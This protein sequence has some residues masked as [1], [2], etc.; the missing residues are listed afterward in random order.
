MSEAK[1]KTAPKQKRTRDVRGDE[2]TDPCAIAFAAYFEKLQ[3]GGATPDQ[4]REVCKL[5]DGHHLLDKRDDDHSCDPESSTFPAN[6]RGLIEETLSAPAEATPAVRDIT[7][8][9]VIVVTIEDGG[10]HYY[11][12]TES[13]FDAEIKLTEEELQDQRDRVES[14]FKSNWHYSA[15]TKKARRTLPSLPVPKTRRELWMACGHTDRFLEACKNDLD[16]A[17]DADGKDVWTTIYAD[18]KFVGNGMVIPFI[19]FE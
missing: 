13:N 8:K 1:K 19:N 10:D 14:H 18:C 4:L 7:G 2:K 12:T 6:L 16:N 11:E 15:A 9:V 5:V 3:K 17:K